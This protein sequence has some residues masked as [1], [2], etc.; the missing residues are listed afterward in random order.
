MQE[1]VERLERIE[2][3]LA[4]PERAYLGTAEAA[5]FLGLSHQQLSQWRMKKEGPAFY[6][7]GKPVRYAVA[8]LHAYMDKLRQEP[9]NG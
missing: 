6:K 5:Q 8:D 9:F 2:A 7:V 4:A 1:I 3:A